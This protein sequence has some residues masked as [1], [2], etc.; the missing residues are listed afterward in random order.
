[1]TYLTR[2]LF[3]GCLLAAFL[4]HPATARTAERS[5]LP[6]LR[7]P[8]ATPLA[9]S[10]ALL[11]RLRAEHD[12]AE[13][14]TGKR[15]PFDRIT[16]Y[17]VPGRNF[18]VPGDTINKGYEIGYWVAPDTIYVAAEWLGLW[19]PRHEMIHDLLQRNH[20]SG[21]TAVFGTACHAMWGYLR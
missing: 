1:M 10:H 9:P 20:W 16:W 5:A 14:C 3:V 19:V 7:V 2:T 4:L 17:T 13:A 15:R 18:R 6:T 12:S 11:Q 21:D 8:G